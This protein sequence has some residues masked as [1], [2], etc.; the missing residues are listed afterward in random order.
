MGVG[1]ERLQQ[2]GR[3]RTVDSPCR[4]RRFTVELEIRRLR[5]EKHL[6]DIRELGLLSVRAAVQSTRLLHTCQLV[7]A[8][9]EPPVLAV[10]HRHRR[11]P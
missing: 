9:R 4:L 11:T 5:R 6:L 8:G 3:I 7:R 1:H 2:V 10:R